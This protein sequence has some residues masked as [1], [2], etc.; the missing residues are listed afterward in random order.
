[1]SYTRIKQMYQPHDVARQD[2][3]SQRLLQHA[4]RIN[5]ELGDV[6]ESELPG[7]ITQRLYNEDIRALNEAVAGWLQ[8]KDTVWMLIDNIDKGWPTRGAT[9]SDIVIVRALLAATRKL[10]KQ[11]EGRDVEFSCLVFLRTDIYEYL[12]QETPDKD[13]DTAINLE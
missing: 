8:T 6:P 5:A 12:L 4:E 7:K 9:S 11:L 1:A 10:Q 3:F 13:K 2:D